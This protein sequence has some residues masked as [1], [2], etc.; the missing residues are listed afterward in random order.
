MRFAGSNSKVPTLSPPVGT[1]AALRTTRRTFRALHLGQGQCP[2][3]IRDRRH[4]HQRLP[5]KIFSAQDRGGVREL[6]GHRRRELGGHCGRGHVRRPRRVRV[7]PRWVLPAHCH[8]QVLLEQERE[9]REQLV[10]AATVRRCARVNLRRACR[11][12]AQVIGGA[13]MPHH[14]VL[15]YSVLGNSLVLS[16]RLVLGYSLSLGSGTQHSA[17]AGDS[18]LTRNPGTLQLLGCSVLGRYSGTLQSGTRVLCNPARHY[19]NSYS[20]SGRVLLSYEAL[21]SALEVLG[22]SVN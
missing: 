11:C 15:H 2:C 6:G 14:V 19:G 1:R 4:E 3:S 9:R 10:R 8:R 21:L 16:N 20:F 12:E 17:G 13:H 18:V 5:R 7:L 22:N